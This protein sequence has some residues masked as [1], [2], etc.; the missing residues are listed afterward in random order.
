MSVRRLPAMTARDISGY[1]ILSHNRR[2][3]RVFAVF[4]GGGTFGA[5]FEPNGPKD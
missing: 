2:D 5:R 1:V 4:S 3:A